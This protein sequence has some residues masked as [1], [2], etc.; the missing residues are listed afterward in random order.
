[1]SFNFK[2]AVYSINKVSG[3]TL[4][5][6]ERIWK[7]RYESA[8]MA[9]E[10]IARHPRLQDLASYIANR[11]DEIEPITAAEALQE[12][13][14]E[15]RRTM[16]WAIGVTK[17]FTSLNP[18]LLDT[19]TLVKKNNRW[20]KNNKPYV[21]ELTDIYELYKIDG[22]TLLGQRNNRNAVDVFAVRCWCTSTE[23]EY[24]I[25]VPQNAA[26]IYDHKT[27]EKPSA[28]KAISWTFNVSTSDIDKI[29][30]QGDIILVKSKEKPEYNYSRHLTA[31]MYTNHLIS[32]T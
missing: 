9:I 22:A 15:F 17:L 16:F 2:E 10:A 23:R 21:Q 31:E 18:T 7:T 20:D 28:L 5:M 1:M 24:W 13:M 4:P 29:Y 14:I 30:R 32:E 12:A 6:A 3:F 11:W 27:G 26:Y 25:Y 8:D 19:V